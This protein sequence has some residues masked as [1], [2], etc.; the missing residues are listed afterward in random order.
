MNT[1]TPRDE[2]MYL[3]MNYDEPRDGLER[4]SAFG[5]E[6]SLSPLPHARDLHD[7]HVE[8][9]QRLDESRW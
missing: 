4:E 3:V 2:D 8:Y 9:R 1:C 5:D 6:R 7:N